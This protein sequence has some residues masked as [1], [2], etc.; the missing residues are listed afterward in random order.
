MLTPS[1]VAEVISDRL[2][3][4]LPGRS[5]QLL[6]ASMPVVS[7]W[8]FVPCFRR[9]CVG[10]GESGTLSS[11][12]PDS[13]RM[14]ARRLFNRLDRKCFRPLYES[15]DV[16]ERNPAAQAGSLDQVEVDSP[17]FSR[18]AA[19]RVSI[20]AGGKADSACH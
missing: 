18:D 2:S 11:S 13:G 19:L 17:L 16:F 8:R 3:A 4:C 6:Q 10:R 20:G 14:Q 9:S 12:S 7:P 15:S 5:R 1:L